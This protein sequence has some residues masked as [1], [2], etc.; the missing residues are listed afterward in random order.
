MTRWQSESIVSLRLGFN[1]RVPPH[2]PTT[3]LMDNKSRRQLFC[4]Y[5]PFVPSCERRFDSFPR[6]FGDL[7]FV[8][9]IC[10]PL[11]NSRDAPAVLLNWDTTSVPPCERRL[12]LI[13]AFVQRFVCMLFSFLLRI[14]LTLLVV[15]VGSRD[16]PVV[17]VRKLL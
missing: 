5:T 15:F 6:L 3:S 2:V 17:A 13:Y 8:L 16:A 9:P 1:W 14:V 11:L 4:Y 7:V 12:C 10:A